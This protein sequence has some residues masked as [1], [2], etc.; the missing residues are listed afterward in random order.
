M[1][2]LIISALWSIV[3]FVASPLW[4]QDV[5]QVAADLQSKLRDP[6][7]YSGSFGFSLQ[8]YSSSLDVQ[9]AAPFAVTAH[10]NLNLGILGVQTPLSFVYASGGTAFNIRLPSFGFAGMSPRYRDYTLHLGDRSL[11]LGKYSFSNHSFRGI[12]GEVNKEKWYTRFFYGRLQRAQISDFNGFERVNPIFRR[13]GWGG[14]IGLQPSASSRVEVSI[15]KG[16]DDALSIPQLSD[17][18]QAF[19]AKENVIIS[20]SLE[21]N[22]GNRIRLAFNGSNS[23]ISNQ[24]TQGERSVSAFKSY[25]GL[26]DVNQ[27][28]R[29]NN[30]YEL[31][32][33]YKAG[34]GTLSLSY[35]RIDPGYRT[36][37]ALFFQDDQENIT[38][39]ITTQL[40]NRKVALVATGGIQNNNLAG[41]R[42]ESYQRFVGSLQANTTLSPKVN[43]NVGFSNFSSVNRQVRIL[44]PSIPQRLT[45]LALTNHNVSAGLRYTVD[46][47]NTL[48]GQFSWMKNQT[49]TT[50]EQVLEQSNAVETIS[51]IYNRQWPANNLSMIIQG[52]YNHFDMIILSQRQ[53]G[54][55]VSFNKSLHQDQV[56]ASVSLGVMQNAQTRENMG[57]T[58]GT[59]IQLRLGANWKVYQNHV[60]RLEAVLL[61]NS[62]ASIQNFSESRLQLSYRAQL[63][64]KEN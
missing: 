24:G 37:G 63:T 39:G 58:R 15:F 27:S 12:G 53:M 56:Q 35:E 43:L 59:F 22:I 49:I 6:F 26:L 38:T 42:A 54:T 55:T 20:L 41:D 64:P 40:F 2:P 62:G 48:M 51:L 25:I 11:T 17:S 13:L 36:L 19:F 23:G 45:E 33:D 29:W 60:M 61:N 52:L 8:H 34:F 31:T 3:T 18:T 44:D 14:L 50:T 30:A 21:Q 4:G 32:T 28:T 7:T 5:E 47:Q 1:R 9:R 10:A 46:P 16:W 57:K